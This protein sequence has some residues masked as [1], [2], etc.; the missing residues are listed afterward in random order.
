MMTGTRSIFRPGRLAP[1]FLCLLAGLGAAAPTFAQTAAK[2]PAKPAARPVAAPSVPLPSALVSTQLI[3]SMLTAV[4]HANKTGNYTVLLAL[5]SPGFQAHNSAASLGAAF[6]PFRTRR[7]DLSEV[8]ILSPT[9]N[10]APT[11]VEPR[12]VRMRGTFQL[13]H[14]PLGFDLQFRWDGGWR[15]DG[16]LLTPP[17]ARLAPAPAAKPRS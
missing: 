13:S 14:G 12:A 4:D 2:P 1:A 9:Y 6:S 11:F 17:P 10:L 8:L 5:G 16:V 7:I 3:A 15:L